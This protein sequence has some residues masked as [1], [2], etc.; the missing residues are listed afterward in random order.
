MASYQNSCLEPWLQSTTRAELDDVDIEMIVG[1]LI[2]ELGDVL[3]LSNHSQLAAAII[4]PCVRS[5]VAWIIEHRGVFQMCY[6]GD[7]MSFD[8]NAHKIYW[9][10]K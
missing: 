3:A 8:K 6:Y 9:G 1:A 4:R 10:H 7:A 5:E 2:H